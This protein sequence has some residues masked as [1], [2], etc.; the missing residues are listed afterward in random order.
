MFVS[1]AEIQ[2]NDHIIITKSPMEQL[3]QR[4]HLCKNKRTSKKQTD[5]K[6]MY[7]IS[8]NHYLVYIHEAF[9]HQTFFRALYLKHPVFQCIPYG[10]RYRSVALSKAGRAM[11]SHK[12]HIGRQA[13][14]EKL[15]EQAL[16][17]ARPI[18]MSTQNRK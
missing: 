8:I 15:L 5:K 1:I 10:E 3:S 18:G 11:D 16:N 9:P 4:S 14:L 12:E 13:W 6:T 2:Q 17:V 7:V